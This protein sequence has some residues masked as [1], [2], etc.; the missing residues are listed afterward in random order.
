MIVKQNTDLALA[1]PPGMLP[2]MTPRPGLLKAAVRVENPE[3]LVAMA[4]ICAARA[5][6]AARLATPRAGAPRPALSSL[7][8]RLAV[9]CRRPALQRRQASARSSPPLP[10]PLPPP[11]VSAAWRAACPPEHSLPHV[12]TVVPQLPSD[13]LPCRHGNQRHHARR[14]THPRRQQQQPAATA[15]GATPSSTTFACA[16]P[17]A[18]CCSRAGWWPSCLAGASPLWSWRSL[19]RCRCVQQ[20][21]S[22]AGWCAVPCRRCELHWLASKAYSSNAGCMR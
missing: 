14:A 1:S 8:P 16:F 4:S 22:V 18:R 10:P 2:Q 3:T 21:P 17:M 19:A 13:P 7:A 6:A 5:C 9:P 12:T 20:G 11:P 15:A